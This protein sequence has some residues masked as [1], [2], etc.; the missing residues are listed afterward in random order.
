L[1]FFTLIIASRCYAQSREEIREGIKHNQTDFPAVQ[2]D[3]MYKAIRTDDYYRI[4]EA[5]R[6]MPTENT[7]TYKWAAKG[8]KLYLSF[9]RQIL[10][11]K[12]TDVI[13]SQKPT[14]EV[15]NGQNHT[16]LTEPPAS[17]AEKQMVDIQKNRPNSVNPLEFGYTL[18]GNWY[19]DLLEKNALRLVGNKQTTTHGKVYILEG[20]LSRGGKV[21]CWVAP[22]RNYLVIRAEMLSKDGSDRNTYE[23]QNIE[24]INGWW[25]P[26]IGVHTWSMLDGGKYRR[27]QET[28]HHIKNIT[29]GT[30]DDGLFQIPQLQPGAQIQDHV[31]G[32]F[33]LVGANGERIFQGIIGDKS[34]APE[35]KPVKS[36]GWL[37]MVSFITL[38]LIGV[39]LFVKWRRPRTA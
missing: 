6:S 37:F 32:K 16:V 22:S 13:S 24:Q 12:G 18:L 11:K 29:V 15:Y 8:S 2:A 19:N 36:S 26:K 23:A 35:Q 1:L 4:L 5:D 34:G 25:F 28:R 39:G 7:G 31:E 30:V 9:D 21:V 38:L 27:I 20:N 14:V 10:T 3:V 17:E 33:F